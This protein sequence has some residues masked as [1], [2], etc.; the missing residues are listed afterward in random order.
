M[1][2][3]VLQFIEKRRK[4]VLYLYKELWNYKAV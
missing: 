2:V 3:V 1:L 4:S